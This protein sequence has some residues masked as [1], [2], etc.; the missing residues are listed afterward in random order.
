MLH[1]IKNDFHYAEEY[2]IESDMD[3]SELPFALEIIAIEGPVFIQAS[4][5]EAW[6][7]ADKLVFPLKIRHCRTGDKFTPFGMKGK[8][9]ISD[10]FINHKFNQL[11]KNQAWLMESSG[12]IVWII[13]ERVGQNCVADNQTRHI[14]LFKYTSI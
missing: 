9:K 12:E 5:T 10:Y 4:K 7:D 14:L 8:V 13:N 1:N 2:L 11:Q 6:F 3:T